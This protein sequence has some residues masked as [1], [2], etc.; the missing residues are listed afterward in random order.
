M[1][2]AL[3]LPWEMA[4]SLKTL[5]ANMTKED[6]NQKHSQLIQPAQRCSLRLCPWIQARKASPT[7]TEL[8]SFLIFKVLVQMS[9]ALGSF[10]AKSRHSLY[11]LQVTYNS[12]F[13]TP[14]GNH[15]FTCVISLTRP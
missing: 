9:R 1:A 5:W 15:L 2:L 6:S 11:T 13:A 14:H 4:K 3:S 7:T 8:N 10:P 12:A